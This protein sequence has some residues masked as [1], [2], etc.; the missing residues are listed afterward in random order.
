MGLGRCVGRRGDWGEGVN[1]RHGSGTF[2]E[3]KM[4]SR[5]GGSEVG[6]GCERL[7]GKLDDGDR[8]DIEQLER[9]NI[10]QPFYEVVGFQWEEVSVMPVL[11]TWSNVIG[12]HCPPIQVSAELRAILQIGRP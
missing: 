11:D 5:E 7:H 8:R 4:E 1:K 2:C 3:R 12:H 6:S 9:I 10:L